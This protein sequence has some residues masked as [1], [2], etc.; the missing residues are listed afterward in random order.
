V[1]TLKKHHDFVNAVTDR[2]M[3]DPVID[4]QEMT[5]IAEQFGLVIKQSNGVQPLA[6]S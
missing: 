5:Q 6:M 4:Q 3:W 2:L 1:A